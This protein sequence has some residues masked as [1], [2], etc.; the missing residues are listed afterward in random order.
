MTSMQSQPTGP[1]A[2]EQG[3]FEARA[4]GATAMTDHFGARLRAAR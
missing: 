3:L 1:E 4:Q 2:G